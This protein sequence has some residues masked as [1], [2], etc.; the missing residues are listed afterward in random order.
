VTAINMRQITNMNMLGSSRVKKPD[1]LS[2]RTVL[3]VAT[4]VSDCVGG[5][6]VL[7]SKAL[8]NDIVW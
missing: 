6:C 4:D 5:Y 2:K 7:S 3:V 8:A 1:T